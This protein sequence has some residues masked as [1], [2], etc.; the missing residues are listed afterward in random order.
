MQFSSDRQRKAVCASFNNRFSNIGGAM[1][2]SFI[3]DYTSNNEKVSSDIDRFV[4]V[5]DVINR[6]INEQFKYVINDRLGDVELYKRMAE[7]VDIKDAIQLNYLAE[8]EEWSRDVLEEMAPRYVSEFSMEPS[9]DDFFV[10]ELLDVEP[11]ILA[12]R[13]YAKKVGYKVSPFV[14]REQ[15]FEDWSMVIGDGVSEE[16]EDYYNMY[17]ESDSKSHLDYLKRIQIPSDFDI[18]INHI[19]EEVIGVIPDSFIDKVQTMVDLYEVEGGYVFIGNIDD[20]AKA[21]EYVR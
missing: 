7:K 10:S 14:P 21:E 8:Q 11:K 9:N 18:P 3:R 20:V 16:L 2:G 4:S 5:S 15:F 13:E 6:P 12:E 19:K 17:L 1:N